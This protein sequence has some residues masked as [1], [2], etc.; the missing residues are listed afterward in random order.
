[1]LHQTLAKDSDPNIQA[2]DV[3][4]E[5]RRKKKRRELQYLLDLPHRRGVEEDWRRLG[6]RCAACRA[7]LPAIG[8][9]GGKWRRA[10][11]EGGELGV[12]AMGEKENRNRRR[13]GGDLEEAVGRRR[14]RRGGRRRREGDEL[15]FVTP[16][17]CPAY[18]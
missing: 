14:R 17:P 1:M 9:G 11:E 6:E 4:E 2:E 8:C 15:G 3:E 5:I 10:G 18:I 13:R 12:G 16:T 7:R